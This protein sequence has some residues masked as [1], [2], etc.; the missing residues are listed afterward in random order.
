M[1]KRKDNPG[2]DAEMRMLMMMMMMT[3]AAAAMMMMMT[4]KRKKT[5]DIRIEGSAIFFELIV[6]FC[7]E[8]SKTVI[9]SRADI[10]R[11]LSSVT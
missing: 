3:A 8:W 11:V 1:K 7:V 2:E 4:V 5:G 10:V 6:S 9:S